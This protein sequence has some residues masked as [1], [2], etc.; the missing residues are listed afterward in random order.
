MPKA[1]D[2]NKEIE[3]KEQ[4]ETLLEEKK[5]AAPL[6][7]VDNGEFS[8]WLDTAKFGQLYRV[9]NVFADSGEMVP[10][11]FRGNHAACMIAVQMA[12][13]LKVDPLMFLQKSYIVKGKPGIEATLAISLANTHGPFEGSI[14]YRIE[15]TPGMTDSS[16]T[17]WA[18]M[19]DSGEVCEMPFTWEDA[20]SPGW[21]S[22]DNWKKTPRLMMMYRSAMWLIRTH[23]PEVILGLHSND[24]L[25]DSDN[26]IDASEV[27]ITSAT[28]KLESIREEKEAGEA[29]VLEADPV[30]SDEKQP[31]E[32]PKQESKAS[33]EP[34]QDPGPDQDE[35][36]TSLLDQGQDQEKVEPK[37]ID[38]LTVTWKL[39]AGKSEAFLSAII[40]IGWNTAHVEQRIKITGADLG[41]KSQAEFDTWIINWGK[42]MDSDEDR[43]AFLA[44]CGCVPPK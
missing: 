20:V 41:K 5:A 2:K 14:K 33:E 10:E 9:A 3:K 29:E 44:M 18:I 36:Q 21:A 42:A 34:D 11:H 37:P 8:N 22:K 12:F 35:E 16:C 13:R 1:K 38:P 28:K 32:E 7:V 31:E 40:A 17:A 26:I 6:P 15:G 30:T 27:N 43:A 24:E 4:V 39:G 25:S 19:K 23:C